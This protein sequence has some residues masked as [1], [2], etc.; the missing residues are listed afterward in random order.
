MNMLSIRDY[1]KKKPIYCFLLLILLVSFSAKLIVGYA[2]RDSFFRRGNSYGALNAIAF[3]LA[4]NCEYAIESGI[5]SIDYEPLY[6]FILAAGYKIFGANWF[7]VTVIQAILFGITS[8]LLFLIGKQLE[9]E[10]AGLIAA[11]YHSFY[12]YLFLHSLSV[13]DTTQ[14]IFVTTLLVY[15]VVYSK[16]RGYP[17][18][19]YGCI[20]SLMGLAFLS[21][22]SALVFLPPVLLYIFLTTEN[23]RIIGKYTILFVCALLTLSP[24]LIRNYL[25]AG[26]FIIST[27]G[28]F[29][30]WQGNNEYSYDYL[31]N[32]ISLDE[33]YR[34]EPRP[35]IYQDN[36]TRP[37]P[38][39]E[40]IKVAQK[41]KSEAARF[42]K[43]NPIEFSKLCWI[44]F[45]K[46]WSLTYNP[47]VSSYAYGNNNIRQCV[48]FVSYAPLLF[49]F[50]FGLYFLKRKSLSIFF[51]FFGILVTYTAA[52]MIVMGFTRARLPLDPFLMVLFGITI[53]T[54][55][56]KI[57]STSYF[58]N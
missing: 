5:P 16:E 46:F 11:T 41:Y 30:L 12:P 39:V 18:W 14:Y 54:I 27:H 45:I 58:Y 42:I 33:V 1:F 25:H 22:G 19:S 15:V 20:G 24:W 38:P 9:N 52:H 21:R 29:G 48:Y 53:S 28:P 43:D 37:R 51:M 8:Y 57:R 31:K 7:G 17:F 34:R 2:I 50:L 32:N 40:A 6:P 26:T 35:R 36:P 4:D 55:Y 13:V 47:V 44:K 23:K 3:N 10:M 49:S 56:T